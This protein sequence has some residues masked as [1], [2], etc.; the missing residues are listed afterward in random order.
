MKNKYVREMRHIIAN[1]SLKN[2]ATGYYINSKSIIYKIICDL[3][4][5]DLVECEKIDKQFLFVSPSKKLITLFSKTV[6]ENKA[7][8][9]PDIRRNMII[10]N[11][12]LNLN[13]LSSAIA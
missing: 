9:T 11:S 10:N 13:P 4:K 7:A 1:Y 6:I 2:S 3:L 8:S 5:R 12:V